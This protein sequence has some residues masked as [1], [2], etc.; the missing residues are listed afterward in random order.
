[1]AIQLFRTVIKFM[2]FLSILMTNSAKDFISFV[3][4]EIEDL[5]VITMNSFDLRRRILDF[6]FIFK[7]MMI[8]VFLCIKSS[9][10]FFFLPKL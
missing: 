2:D 10:V 5:F 7:L 3:K 4:D 6:V 1:M 9:I 8:N